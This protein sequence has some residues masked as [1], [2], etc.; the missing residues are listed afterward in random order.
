L[1][2]VSSSFLV[3][4]PLLLEMKLMPKSRLATIYR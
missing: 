4:L 3:C 1:K 2:M